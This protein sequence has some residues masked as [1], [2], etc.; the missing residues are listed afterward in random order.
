[1]NTLRY[2]LTSSGG[3]LNL[4]CLRSNY[5][6]TI[7]ST[8]GTV[9]LASSFSIVDTY[10]VPNRPI[11][12]YFNGAVN[13]NGFT[14][15]ICGVTIPQ[16]QLAFSGTFVFTYDGTAYASQYQP[17]N[18]ETPADNV[19]LTAVTVLAAGGSLTLTP[20][21]S[22]SIL[23]LSGSSVTLTN[24][25]TVSLSTTGATAGTTFRVFING[26]ITLSTFALTVAGVSISA[27][28]ALNG[29]VEVISVY[30]GSTYDTVYVNKNIPLDKVSVTGLGSGDDGKI[31]SYDHA[32]GK[33]SAGFIAA[34]NFSGSII[35]L[36]FAEVRVLAS[37]V[38]AL[39]SSPKT[40]IAAPGVGKS[41]SIM[42]VETQLAFG[43]AAYTTNTS[44]RLKCAGA[45]F[46]LIAQ[47]DILLS[48]VSRTLRADTVV[49]TSS[50]TTNTQVV[51]NAAI[52]AYVAT[53]NPAAG[54]SDLFIRV[55]YTITNS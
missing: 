53:G 39:N 40:I 34:D 47:G 37:E 43:T 20:G 4:D 48:T 41:I 3:T 15:T 1:M 13:L 26:G 46:D 8:T 24:N 22:K 55:W 14:F 32:T 9:T 12:V 17:D 51:D 50:G 35:P 31:V 27:Y 6:P 45:G 25:Y 30:N 5:D 19:G 10:Q 21:V 2:Q 11:V 29:N 54:D 44:L 16:S 36:Y 49:S 52:Q 23:T 42:S 33:Y 38:L 28:D 18:A 7:V